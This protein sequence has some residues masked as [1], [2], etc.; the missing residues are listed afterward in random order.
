MWR[1]AVDDRK[2]LKSDICIKAPGCPQ[3]EQVD[4][5]RKERREG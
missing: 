1:E 3:K 4:Q 5:R 2:S